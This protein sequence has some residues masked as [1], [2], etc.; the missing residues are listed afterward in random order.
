MKNIYL[1]VLCLNLFLASCSNEDDSI[2]SPE[3]VENTAPSIPVQIY[4][5]KDLVCIENTIDFQWEPSNDEEENVI[6]YEVEIATD[7][8]FSEGLQSASTLD[9]HKSITVD[10]GEM[11]YWRIKATDTKDAS[12]DYSEVFNFYTEGDGIVNYL[13]FAPDLVSPELN[14]VQSGGSIELSWT[15]TD[16]DENN[17][18]EYDVYFGQSN[19]PTEIIATAITSNSVTVDEVTHGDYFWK[20]VVRDDQGGATVGQVWKFTV[21]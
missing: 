13:P 12:S 14:S 6:R 21:E 17:V 5:S 7:N 2:D 3:P 1:L 19:P 10:R 20:V 15:A 8:N 4:P 16:A 18:L 11:Y 9:V